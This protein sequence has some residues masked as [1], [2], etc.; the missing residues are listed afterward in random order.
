MIARACVG[1][2]LLPV[3]F[4]ATACSFDSDP[5][6]QRHAN[7][8]Q[9]GS[10][11]SSGDGGGSG[12]RVRIERGNGVPVGEGD[13][14]PSGLLHGIKN[15]WDSV[16]DAAA[17][18][19]KAGGLD[20]PPRR[21]SPVL[22]INLLATFQHANVRT[23]RWLGYLVQ[24]PEMHTVHHARGIHH[25]N[26]ADL[27]LIDLLFGTFR[28]PAGYEHATGFWH[29]AS[30]RVGDMLLLRDVSRPALEER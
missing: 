29:G 9:A 16:E 30:A 13:S 18:A 17:K 4:C 26:Y 24:R 5:L 10:D 22:A 1:L 12:T 8:G 11:G 27:P 3:A 7:L 28:N 6:P 2:L 21:W 25:H 15:A 23:P 19:F 14:G 20:V